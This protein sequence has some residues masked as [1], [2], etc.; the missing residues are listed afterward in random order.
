MSTKSA[1]ATPVIECVNLAG[2]RCRDRDLR[3]V[4]EQQLPESGEALRVVIARLG[5]LRGSIER[6]AAPHVLLAD[7]SSALQE[8]CH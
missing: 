5:R 2:E 6:I 1:G 7:V 8:P 4:I 3:S